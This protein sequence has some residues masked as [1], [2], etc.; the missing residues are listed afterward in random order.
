VL[1]LSILDAG[2]TAVLVTMKGRSIHPRK[3]RLS[4]WSSSGRLWGVCKGSGLRAQGLGL[5]V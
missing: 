2:L 1:G 5:Q 3:E 4:T